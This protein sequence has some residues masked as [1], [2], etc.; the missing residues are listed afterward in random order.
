MKMVRVIAA[1]LAT[2][3]FSAQVIASSHDGYRD[4]GRRGGDLQQPVV[5]EYVL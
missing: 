1:V 5:Y 4:G 2:L 3:L